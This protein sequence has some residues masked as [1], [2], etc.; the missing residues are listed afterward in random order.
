MLKNAKRTNVNV[1]ILMLCLVGS[2]LYG[3]DKPTQQ[4][5]YWSKSYVNETRETRNENTTLLG[6]YTK[7]SATA[8][9]AVEDIL[10]IGA[11]EFFG[12]MDFSDPANP[13]EI[14]GVDTPAEILDIKVQG[15][16]AYIISWF[17]GFCIVDISDLSSPFIV[18]INNNHM[19]KNFGIKPHNNELYVYSMSG[20]A[21][22]DITNPANIVLL[23]ELAYGV[24]DVVFKEDL[25]FISLTSPGLQLLIFDN[26]NPSLPVQTSSFVDNG[27]VVTFSMYIVEDYLYYLKPGENVGVL[28]ISDI[29]NIVLEGTYSGLSSAHPAYYWDIVVQGDYAYLANAN[30]D[31]TTGDA[32]IFDVLNIADPANISQ[33]ER[34]CNPTGSENVA[35]KIQVSNDKAYVAHQSSGLFTFDISDPEAISQV[36]HYE[37][38]GTMIDIDVNDG[39]AYIAEGFAGLYGIDVSSPEEPS[40]MGHY[41]TEQSSYVFSVAANNNHAYVTDPWVE[42]LTTGVNV[43]NPAEMFNE[44]TFFPADTPMVPLADDVEF[45]NNGTQALIS[46]WDGP[47][48]FDVLADGNLEFV[49]YCFIGPTQPV[50]KSLVVD[51]YVY[52]LIS[53]NGTADVCIVNISDIENPMVTFYLS[54]V[55][56][57]RNLWS[58]EFKDNILY[59][60]GDL[61]TVVALDVSDP[62]SPESVFESQTGNAPVFDMKI[63][64]DCLFLAA[65]HLFIYDIS[66]ASE[67]EVVGS[68]YSGG[69]QIRSLDIDSEGL[70]YLADYGGLYVVQND[71]IPSSNHNN[72]TPVVNHELKQNYPNPF[73]PTT[74]ISFNLKSAQHVSVEVFNL[75]GNLVKTLQSGNLSSGDHQVVW[76]GKNS[77]NEQVASGV[78]LYKLKSGKSESVKKMIMMK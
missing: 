7:G 68:F 64:D 53:G 23:T 20:L 66:T 4:E 59:A 47:V 34:I 58:L 15:D 43:S 74:S 48:F 35:Y 69:G 44:F 3:V 19:A 52:C 76:N 32:V 41:R 25:M 63:K 36:H 72:N 55:V 24:T 30:V 70:V 73:N 8:V 67:P 65:G 1:L 26:S 17:A 33:V 50:M 40:Y 45:F 9:D 37:T 6:R 46:Y 18:D 78:Y 49:S 77:D 11:G 16:Y 60:G 13:I 54:S 62:T 71:Y 29:E 2:F 22:Y 75:K 27:M 12:I 31:P 56:S 38:G 51:N 42:S 57:D 28:N 39:V 14:G 10:F 21:I 61:G 5:N